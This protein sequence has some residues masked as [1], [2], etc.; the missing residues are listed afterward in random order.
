MRQHSKSSL[1]LMELIIAILFFALAS[2]ICIQLFVYAHNKTR[3]SRDLSLA[4]TQCESAAELYRASQGN[5]SALAEP[6]SA[7]G[8]GSVLTCYYNEHGVFC[9]PES[10]AYQML[11]R[12]TGE[13]TLSTLFIEVYA[14]SGRQTP[15]AVY[16]LTV[17][18][19]KPYRAQ[20]GAA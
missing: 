14:L 19:H 5:L 10:G 13:D 6:L 4:M 2:G 20:R 15:T 17:S 3:D 8:G 11:L 16:T 7:Q 12:E 9:P 18:V 1:F